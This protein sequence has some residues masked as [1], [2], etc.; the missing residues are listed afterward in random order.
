MTVPPD[1][2]LK[3]V[4]L[5]ARER[6][7]ADAGLRRRGIRA[8]L[9]DHGRAAGDEGARH[10]RPP[11]QARRQAAIP[12]SICRGSRPTSPAIL[13]I[14]AL[15]KLKVWYETHTAATGADR[16]GRSAA[17][18]S[19]ARDRLIAHDRHGARR[20]ARQAHAAASP[21]RCRSRSSRSAARPCIDFALDRLA[22]AGIEPA[23]VNVHHLADQVE[24]HL[25][26]RREPP[27]VDLRRARAAARNRRRPEEGAAPSRRGAV[28]HASIRIRSGS[29]GRSRNLVRFLEAWEPAR[30]DILMLLAATAT[31][32]GYEGRG[33]FAMDA[34]GRLR[35]R[36]RAR[37][38]ALRLCRRRDREAGAPRRHAGRRRSRPISSTTGRSRP[39]GSSA[40]ASTESGCMLA[41]PQRSPPRRS[42]SPQA[43]GEAPWHRRLARLL[44]PARLPVPAD[45]RRR[46]CRRRPLAGLP[47]RPR[48]SAD[49]TIYLPTRRAA[50]ALAALLAERGGGRAQ[51]L[52]RIVPL[53]EADE[54]EFDLDRARGLDDR[55]GVLAPPIPPARAPADPDAPGAALVGGGRPRPRCGSR[56]TSRSSCRPRPPMRWR[57]RAISKR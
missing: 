31:S 4:S 1:L 16:G 8:R 19:P 7:A 57:S 23:V 32:L 28:P 34:A 17:A 41:T 40:C 24:A 48:R 21:R 20:R 42:A 3:L 30:M 50:R 36:Q 29:R 37:G 25:Q 27:I 11:R 45:P 6:K 26:R 10:L 52:P 49:A 38:D 33:D 18:L 35:R 22:E 54:A 53:G 47:G 2:E 15:A 12:R 43:C 51:L 39:A 13:R 14:P 56:P 5:Y 9:R 55:G 46:A 44:D